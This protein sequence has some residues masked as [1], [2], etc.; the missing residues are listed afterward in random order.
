MYIGQADA[1]A[2]LSNV[3]AIAAGSWHSIAV[4]ADGTAVMWGGNGQGQRQPPP[5]LPPVLAAAGGAGHTV[6]IQA[7]TTAVAWGENTN[8]QCDIPATVS[9]IVSVA[10]GNS[11]S[12]VLLGRMTGPPQALWPVWD[13]TQLGVFLSTVPGRNYALEF[14]ENMTAPNW[15]TLPEVRGRGGAQVLFDTSGSASHRFYRVRQW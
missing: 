3:V 13:G 2:D 8:G 1:P 12:I 10:A 15:T 14:K 7:N 4:R 6:A 9:N 11:H 5:G